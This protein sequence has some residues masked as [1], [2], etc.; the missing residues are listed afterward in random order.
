MSKL[1][2]IHEHY[3]NHPLTPDLFR[4]V[5][6]ELGVGLECAYADIPLKHPIIVAPGQVTLTVP[7]LR[8][9]QRAGYAGCVLKSV[10]GEDSTGC[11]RMIAQR[12]KPTHTTTVYDPEDSLGAHPIIHWDGRCDARSLPEYIPF[13]SAARS[14]HKTGDFT[15][16]ASLLCHLPRPGEEPNEHEWL[17]TTSAIADLGYTHIEIDFCPFLAG[18][19]YTEDQRNVL[20]WYRT[21]PRLMKSTRV[22][23]KVFPKMLNLEWGLDYQLRIAEAAVDGGANGLVVANRFFK[24]EY[25]SAHGGWELRERNLAQVAAIHDQ[26]PALPLSATGGIYTGGH[27]LA[28]LRAGARNVQVLSFIMG[29][30][31]VPFAKRDGTKAEKV[32]HKLLLDPEDG[33]FAALLRENRG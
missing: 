31:R 6:G 12:K 24:K 17:H 13:A 20:S 19:D 7:G 8:T 23:I 14:L 18:D 5:S 33:L 28:Y 10:V 4:Q 25:N 32:L 16:I 30:V 26:F 15:V 27:V 3:S 22:G 11:C 2:D 29:Q 21:L 1:T 9:L